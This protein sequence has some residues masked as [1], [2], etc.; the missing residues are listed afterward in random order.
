MST[1]KKYIYSSLLLLFFAMGLYAF[2]SSDNELNSGAVKVALRNVGHELLL[3]NNDSTSLVKPIASQNEF[4]YLLSF[5][6]PLSIEPA[7][8]VASVK[9]NFEKAV[10]FNFYRVEVI[11]CLTREVVYSYEFKETEENSII[12]CR[13]RNLAKGCYSIRFHFIKQN[14]SFLTPYMAGFGFLIFF[15]IGV[16]YVL[17]R[18]NKEKIQ[19]ESEDEVD[20]NE[21]GF[22]K[23]YPNQN[24]LVKGTQEVSLSKKECEL[25]LL[26]IKQ[27][28]QIISREELTKRVWEDNG[29]FVGR[30]LDTYISKLRKKL[31]QDKLIKITNIHGV[32]Y[33]LEIETNKKTSN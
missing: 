9:T 20:Y 21:I 32:G 27:P 24:K 2:L 33:K 15:G 31:Q 4:D 14:W 3:Q 29:V 6:S 16:E 13:G 17:S 12:P 23:F 30:S 1:K 10:V 19:T 5:Q 18:N 26:F 7:Q 22:F 28:N 25:L 11:N 8:L